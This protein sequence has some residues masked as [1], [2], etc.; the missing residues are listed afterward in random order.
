MRGDAAM[1]LRLFALGL[2]SVGALGFTLGCLKESADSAAPVLSP[3]EAK[4]AL[5]ELIRNSPD[6][7]EVKFDPDQYALKPLEDQGP[8]KYRMGWFWIDVPR[9]SYQLHLVGKA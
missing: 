9:T 3:E 6:T 7:F 1:H 4:E 8:G 5:V 2:L